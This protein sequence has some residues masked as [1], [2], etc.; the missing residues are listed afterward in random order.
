M[1]LLPP[2]D[3][4]RRIEGSGQREARGAGGR[5]VISY[6]YPISR[7]PRRGGKGLRS[8]GLVSVAGGGGSGH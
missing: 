5:E 6:K 4:G 2:H 3:Q 1:G 7:I 8:E